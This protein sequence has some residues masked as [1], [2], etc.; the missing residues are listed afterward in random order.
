MRPCARLSFVRVPHVQDGLTRE[1]GR[2]S[3]KGSLGNKCDLA[4]QSDAVLVHMHLDFS[5][6]IKMLR[7]LFYQNNRQEQGMVAA[8]MEIKVLNTQL[9]FFAVFLPQ[10]SMLTV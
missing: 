3:R 6:K 8:F 9:Q 4:F 10:V 1:F 7:G 5:V 2:L